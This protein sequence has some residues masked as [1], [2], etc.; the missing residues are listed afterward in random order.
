MLRQ[1]FPGRIIGAKARVNI[2]KMFRE[3]ENDQSVYMTGGDDYAR[4]KS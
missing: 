3:N 1:W 4:W 2:I